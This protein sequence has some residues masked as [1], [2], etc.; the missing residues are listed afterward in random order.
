LAGLG[1]DGKKFIHLRYNAHGALVL[2]IELPHPLVEKMKPLRGLFRRSRTLLYRIRWV[3]RR[4]EASS[5]ALQKVPNAPLSN[6][7]GLSKKW[8]LFAGS[9]GG[10]ESSDIE[11]VG[12]VEEM[13]PLRGLCT[14]FC[15][16]YW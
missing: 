12:S 8:S 13:K 1:V 6:S 15:V 3:C 16:T 2:R 14:G 7:L 9:S 11:F 10:P 4:N 5:R